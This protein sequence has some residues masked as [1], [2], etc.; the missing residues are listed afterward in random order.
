MKTKIEEKDKN[1]ETCTG[2]TTTLIR[3]TKLE[4]IY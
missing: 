3:V 1:S 4:L 2:V